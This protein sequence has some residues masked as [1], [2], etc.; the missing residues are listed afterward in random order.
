MQMFD[1]EWVLTISD[2]FMT[3]TMCFDLVRCC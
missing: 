2:V 1:L 3:Y